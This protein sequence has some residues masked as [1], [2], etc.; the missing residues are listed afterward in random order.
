M[1]N[2]EKRMK[3][4]KCLSRVKTLADVTSSG[5]TWHTGKSSLT[6]AERKKRDVKHQARTIRMYSCKRIG[7]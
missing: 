4:P 3:K 1:K 7:R 5:G 6:S 2:K